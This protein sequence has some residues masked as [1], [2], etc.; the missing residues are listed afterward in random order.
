MGEDTFKRCPRCNSYCPAMRDPSGLMLCPNYYPLR[1]ALFPSGIESIPE[2]EDRILRWL[3]G[4]ADQTTQA[5]LISLFA[6]A[7]AEATKAPPACGKCGSAS[8]ATK[9]MRVY[10]C[11]A[12]GSVFRRRTE[13]E[14]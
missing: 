12:C 1:D 6:R 4:M 13:L 9:T 14:G 3:A 8:M 7:L 2:P 10:A 11:T 5:A